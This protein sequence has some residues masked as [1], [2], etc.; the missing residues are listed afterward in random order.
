MY[1]SVKN[2]HIT[3]FLTGTA[4]L[5]IWVSGCAPGTPVS[6]AGSAA[7]IR[8][9]VEI[10]SA[11]RAD[12]SVGQPDREP[13]DL[14]VTCNGRI[15]VPPQSL[16][17]LSVP[18]GGYI[19]E[20]RPI[21][22]EYVTKGSLL[23]VLEHPTYIQMQQDYLEARSQWEYLQTE[24]T[25]QETLRSE[26]AATGKTYDKT[27][28]DLQAADARMT[29]LSRQLG[30][31][32]ISTEGLTPAAMRSRVEVRAPFSGYVLE[33]PVN[34]GVYAGPEAVLLRL[35]DKGHLHVELEVFEQDAA[36]ISTRAMIECTIA[37]VAYT[38][39]VKLISQ[40]VRPETKTISVHA[41]L[42]GAQD[43][44]RPGAY[45]AGKIQVGRDTALVVPGTALVRDGGESFMFVQVGHHQFRR[46]RVE[47]E[48]WAYKNP[49][50]S[51]TEFHIKNPAVISDFPC[52]LSG[53]F[54]LQQQL[55]GED[56]E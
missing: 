40:E 28:A 12:L 39:H 5:L 54:L 44:L 16:A 41:H 43:A 17:T 48:A 55:A 31:L 47:A 34:V 42:D 2:I 27:K 8:D 18:V 13:Y 53:A 25:R 9:V 23:A 33:V 38:G 21:N 35:I 49:L 4:A 1:F 50:S 26:N 15:D 6:E 11:L 52:V 51:S 37:G 32:G 14:W 30:L 10:D 20:I 19:R 46:V 56:A 7:V 45:V 36:R 24:L 29:G 3:R 22:G